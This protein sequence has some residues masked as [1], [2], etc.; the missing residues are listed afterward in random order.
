[1]SASPRPQTAT[2][3]VATE[4]L[5]LQGGDTETMLVPATGAS[6][7]GL[8]GWRRA[9]EAEF[10]TYW[11]ENT[12]KHVKIKR[13]LGI[14]A[15]D[16]MLSST[17]TL[18]SRFAHLGRHAEAAFWWSAVADL[19]GRRSETED[20]GDAEIALTLWSD[21][22]EQ[23]AAT[24]RAAI[25]LDEARIARNSPSAF[26]YHTRHEVDAGTQKA[27]RRRMPDFTAPACQNVYAVEADGETA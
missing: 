9:T 27:R 7:S 24:L 8:P 6:L 15:M 25:T 2:Q 4:T 14:Q 22:L 10:A 18:A 1:M 16:E 5:R 13:V 12:R 26:D 17:G 20:G 19:A 23:R 21:V 11:A 3:A